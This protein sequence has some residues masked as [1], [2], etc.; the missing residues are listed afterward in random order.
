MLRFASSPTGDMHIGHLRVALLNYI[1]SRQ[2]KEDLIVRIEDMD[3]E[4]KIEGKDQEILDILDLFGIKYTQTIYQSQNYKFHSAMALQLLHEK[5]AFSC[6]CS[7]EWLNKK[8]QEAREADKQYSYDDACRNLPAELVI[9]NTNPFRIRINR[10]DDNIV[11]NDKVKGEV[12]FSPD[13]VDS[14]IIMNQDKTPTYDFACGIDDMLSDISLI[15]RGEDQISNAPKQEHIRTSLG[16][17]KDLEYAHLPSI[18]NEDK[19]SVKSLLE[20]GFLPEAI[21][22]YLISTANE[23][24]CKIFNID[25]AIDF[26]DLDK[27][28]DSPT[29]FTIEELKEINREHLKN[30]DAKE[31]SRYVGFADMEIGELARIYLDDASTT[32]ELKEKIKPIFADKKIPSEFKEQSEI[33]VKVIQESPF[34]E[35]FED[36]KNYILEKSSIKEEDFTKSLSYIL[37]G[38]DNTPDIAKVYK[39]LKNYI[40][41]IVK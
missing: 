21:S 33:M 22:N 6:F 25:D 28:S 40:G 31:L 38:A 27:I 37:T 41:E 9:D 13:E 14:F 35:K 3:K 19:F 16:Y 17:E 18:S 4:R 23:A 36:F 20:Q 34:F 32:K 8:R 12:V 1:V 5:K 24:P 2:K 26:F 29:Y 30:L 10:P 15:I 11:I 7:D 39:Y